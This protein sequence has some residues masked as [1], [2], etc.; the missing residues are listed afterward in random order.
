[1]LYNEAMLAE[2]VMKQEAGLP[3][4]APGGRLVEAAE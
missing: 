2:A 1:M 3:D 4:L